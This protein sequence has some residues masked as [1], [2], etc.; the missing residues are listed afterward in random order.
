[1]KYQPKG[2]MCATCLYKSHDCSKLPFDKMPKHSA[3]GE[4]TIVI[5]TDYTRFES[6]AKGIDEKG[7]GFIVGEI[8]P[9]LSL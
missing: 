5:C 1:M 9:E 7:R 4:T 6:G 2:G 8:S 3:C